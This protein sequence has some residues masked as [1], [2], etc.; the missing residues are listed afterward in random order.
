MEVRAV[1]NEATYRATLAQVSALFG[2]DPEPDTPEGEALE[3]MAR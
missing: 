2:L 1:R 3:V